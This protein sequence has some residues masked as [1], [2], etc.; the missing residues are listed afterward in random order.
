MFRLWKV[1]FILMVG[2]MLASC[3]KEEAAEQEK[4]T[5]EL[6]VY[7]TIYPLTFF[8]QEIGKDLVNV[9]SVLPAGVDEH[10]YEPTSKT[11]MDI[12][13][14][15]L[16]LYNGLGL[17]PF[18]DKLQQSLEAEEVRIVEVGDQVHLEETAEEPHADH[19]HEEHEGHDHG[20]V[21]PHIW[22]DPQLAAQM[23][24]VVKEELSE[25]RPEHQDEFEQNYQALKKRLSELD[26]QFQ[27][28]ADAASRKEFIVS[29]AAFGYWERY[30]LEQVSIAGLS[31]TSEPSQKE[32]KEIIETAK[33]HDTKY[34]V[35]EQNVT[36]RVAEVVQR[37]LNAEA[38]RVHNL[39]VLTEEDIAKE[40][41]YFT[42]ME[43]NIQT[44]Q[45]ATEE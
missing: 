21:D 17:E 1:A 13:G 25:L 23:A 28:M 29:H 32:L 30:G 26:G 15:D 36:P 45:K 4:Q 22:I 40:E 35:F 20:S 42:L 16:F 5:G 19:E 31:P 34:I 14:G 11:M 24:E 38:L 27:E 12:A 2:I 18:G 10:T 44:L 41:N 9:E 39:S 37:E 6:T 43:K 33:A 8:T 3:G 7:T